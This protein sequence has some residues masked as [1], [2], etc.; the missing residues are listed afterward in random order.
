VF[1]VPALTAAQVLDEALKV[2][3][4]DRLLV[5]GAGGATGP[6]LVALGSL[7]GA[8][9]IATAGPR[10]HEPIAALGASHV[11]DYHKKDWPA[12]VLALT[13]GSGGYRCRKRRARRREGRDPSGYRRRSL[14]NNHL[15][16]AP[17]RASHHGLK[18]LRETGR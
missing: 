2:N 18:H 4:G 7:R 10:S 1:A 15:R 14:G 5:N 17:G 11:I 8:E 13:G 9:V 16:P 12:Q 3:V 6:L